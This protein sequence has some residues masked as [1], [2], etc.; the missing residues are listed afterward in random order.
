L[1]A[2]QDAKVPARKT[3]STVTAKQSFRL[4]NTL[5]EVTSFARVSMSED[6]SGKTE[7]KPSPARR[8][9]LL[10]AGATAL[11]IVNMSVGSEAQPLAVVILQDVALALGLLALVGGLIMM[12]TRK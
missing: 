1:K 3:G 2:W 9:A 5:A 4:P 10:G 8:I 6:Q 11:A 12:M 7:K